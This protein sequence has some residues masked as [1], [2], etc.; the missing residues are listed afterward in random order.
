MHARDRCWTVPGSTA[1][2][3]C[4]LAS[5]LLAGCLFSGGAEPSAPAPQQGFFTFQGE[6]QART[7]DSGSSVS[8]ADLRGTV[9][10]T[11]D[12]IRVESTHGSCV[13][14]REETRT[15]GN[16]RLALSCGETT[17]EFGAAAGRATFPGTAQK[18]VPAGCAAY[19][20]VGRAQT[21]RC[22]E[23]RYTTEWVEILIAAS[24]ALEPPG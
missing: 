12:E 7:M 16:G 10:F 6:F 14:P 3:S 9:E 22:I 11:P 5:L 24:F 20:I 8:R 4:L 2:P 1:L 23:Y 19:E 17:F 21:R 15:L 13:V 18:R